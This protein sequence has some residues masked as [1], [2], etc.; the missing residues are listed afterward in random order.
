M[1]T[2]DVPAPDP[3]TATGAAGGARSSAG[4]PRAAVLVGNPA[5]P[6]SRA[7]RIAR[8]LVDEGYAVEIA[9]VAG[10]GVSDRELDGLI[11]TRRYRPSG[12]FARVAATYRTPGPAASRRAASRRSRW[13]G[14]PGR[15]ARAV[16]GRFW[17]WA[18]WP[19]TVRGWWRTLARELPPADLYH[20][21]GSL[22]IGAALAARDRDRRAGR[23]S[24]VIYDAIDFF[25]ESNNVLEMPPI[26]RR[27]LAWRE[28]RWARAADAI[29]TVNEPIAD[30]VMARMHPS[31]RPTVVPNYPEAQPVRS[32]RPDLIR[33][34][35]GL[36]AHTRVVL[37]QGRLGPN[38]GLDEA[39]AAILEVEDAA[40]VL[41]GFGRWSDLCRARDQDPTYRGRHFTLPARHPDELIEWTASA[42]VALI[43]LP[44]IS[45]NQRHATPN[46]F[47]EAIA[48]GTPIV[49][50]PDLPTME[51]ILRAEDLGRVARSLH[52]GDLASA[53][54]EILDVPGP[55]RDAWHERIA[56]TGRS[57]YAWPIAAEAYRAVVRRWSGPTR[58]G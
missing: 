2:V 31:E 45:Y 35:L 48:A 9:A 28:A 24:R 44:A 37:F 4:R 10:E 15:V 16:A 3:T 36:A 5:A 20:A 47:L 1:P 40:L 54:T 7:L 19:H 58:S 18:F 42:D 22:P 43:P 49:L 39:A 17:R 27:W 51:G 23:R 30:R 38:L 53:I 6:Y 34:E 12:F 50:G 46:K 26:V 11:E 56:A 55:E 21:C 57:R 32:V 29:V 33:R 13:L 41:L 52:P 14:M 8:A 25:A